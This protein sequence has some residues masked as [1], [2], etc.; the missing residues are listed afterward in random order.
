MSN[1]KTLKDIR[2]EY[3][4]NTELRD[5]YDRMTDDLRDAAREWVKAA[6]GGQMLKPN[7]DWGNMFRCDEYSCNLVENWIKHFFNLEDE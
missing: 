4:I 3:E 6:K 7:E 5:D 1:L 2:R